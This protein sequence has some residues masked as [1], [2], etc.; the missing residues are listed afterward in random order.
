M[1]EMYA[2]RFALAVSQLWLA[3]RI[4]R[5]DIGRLALFAVAMV[6]EGVANL[7]PIYP[8]SREWWA[9]IFAPLA[10]VRLLLAVAVTVDLFG[11]LRNRTHPHERLA[12]AGLGLVVGFGGAGWHWAPANWLDTFTAARQYGLLALAF[13]ASGMWAWTRFGRPVYEAPRLERIE[14]YDFTVQ[15]KRATSKKFLE[16]QM[17]AEMSPETAGQISNGLNGI[18]AKSR[19]W[20][21][22]E[23]R[24]FCPSWLLWLWL[25]FAMSSTGAG[26]LARFVFR[27]RGQTWRTAGDVMIGLEIV[28]VAWWL[29]SLRDTRRPL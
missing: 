27:W 22:G 15:L 28:M 13:G 19:T 18:A 25:A 9:W 8:H 26:G 4:W 1:T 14:L 21:A 2:L 10:T 24:G 11:F 23:C 5:R 7:V 20:I 12:F 16:V 17:S 29:F 3:R 6:A